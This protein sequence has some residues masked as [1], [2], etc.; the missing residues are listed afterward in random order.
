[1]T[2]PAEVGKD[3]GVAVRRGFCREVVGDDAAC[4]QRLSITT[5]WPQ[6]S[7]KRW[8]IARAV[9]SFALPAE[10]GTMTRM[11]RIGYDCAD[12]AVAP[13]Q[14]AAINEEQQTGPLLFTCDCSSHIDVLSRWHFNRRTGSAFLLNRGL[15]ADCPMFR[16]MQRTH[17][18]SVRG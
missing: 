10:P 3:Q 14:V 7:V 11:G 12:T 6:A 8:A 17:R 15:F 1:M 18:N 13:A 2:R 4:S 5:C 16:Q 9:K